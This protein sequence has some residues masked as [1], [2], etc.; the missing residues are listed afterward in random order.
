MQ[1]IV[2]EQTV[3]IVTV[4]AVAALGI[5]RANYAT[6]AQ[7]TRY[8]KYRIQDSCF[9]SDGKFYLL[10]WER[11]RNEERSVNYHVVGN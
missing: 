8:A 3:A 9:Y 2:L 5:N 1:N 6:A 11:S 4:Y 10:L 7:H